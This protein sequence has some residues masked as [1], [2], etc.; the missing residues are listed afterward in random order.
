MK[1]WKPIQFFPLIW[2]LD[3]LKKINKIIQENSFEQKKR[4]P[5][6]KFNPGLALISLRTTG[7]SSLRPGTK[8]FTCGKW[9][10]DYNFGI[11]DG[12]ELKFGTHKE[13]IVLNILKY[14]NIVL[15]SNAICQLEWPSLYF[16]KKLWAKTS[17]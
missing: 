15:I 16:N 6:L 13:P 8:G 2:W 1:A 3:A 4:K 5:R 17:F 9:I 10:I 12:A 14:I 7:P 11:D